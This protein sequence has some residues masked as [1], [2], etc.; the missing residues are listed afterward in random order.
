MDILNAIPDAG[1]TLGPAIKITDPIMFNVCLSACAD[2]TGMKTISRYWLEYIH[3]DVEHMRITGSNGFMMASTEAVDFSCWDGARSMLIRPERPLPA[4]SRSV[5][6]YRDQQFI[7]GIDGYGRSFSIPYLM[8]TAVYQ[9]PDVSPIIDSIHE[10]NSLL[11]DKICINHRY[12]MKMMDAINMA[13]CYPTIRPYRINNG[14]PNAV[15]YAID[16]GHPNITS[17]YT[18]IITSVNQ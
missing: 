4:G 9:Y 10:D 18:A 16:F 1:I 12:L 13:T 8:S 11:L 15:G 6:I 5:S 17:N 7:T 14:N 3:V 2:P